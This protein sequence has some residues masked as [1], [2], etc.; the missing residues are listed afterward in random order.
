MTESNR[1]RRG[2]PPAGQQPGDRVTDYPQLALRIPPPTLRRLQALARVERTPQWRILSK[3]L[4][5][6]I[7]QLPDDQRKLIGTLVR[8]AGRVLSQTPKSRRQPPPAVPITLLNVDDN[9]PMLF[10]RSAMFRAEGYQVIEAQNGHTALEMARRHRP[11]VVLLDVH[12][13]DINGIEICRRIKADPDT[14]SIKVVQ[15]SATSKSP[16]DQVYGLETG[17]A[18][19][20]LT[21][22][23]PRGTLLSVVNRLV[24][25]TAA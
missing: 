15:V 11:D 4:E 14:S 21:E 16:S 3:V 18:D 23:L 8:R 5:N 9:E 7:A 13:P 20:F 19:M 2:R 10:A 25:G 24:K 1:R 6:Y 17:G 12:L 22:P